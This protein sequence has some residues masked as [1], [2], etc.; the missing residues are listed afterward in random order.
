MPPSAARP[1]GF[2]LSLAAEGIAPVIGGCAGALAGGSEGGVAGVVVGQVVER[3]INYFGPRIVQNWLGWLR[4]QPR[5]GQLAAIAEL[6]TLPPEV[7]RREAAAAVDR[8]AAA[9]CSTEDRTLAV[10]YLTAIPGAVQ[11]SLVRDRATGA[12]TLLAAAAPDSSQVLLRLLP[13]DVPPYPAGSVLPGTSYRLEEL[14]GTGGFGAVYRATDPTLQ[15][16]TLAIK[17]CLEPSM[18]TTLHQ[19]R[20]ILDR[21]MSAGE[22]DWSPGIVRLYGY[23]LEHATPFLVYEYVPG[24]DLGAHLA[25]RQAEGKPP[26]PREVL[27][28]VVQVVEALAFAHARGLVH[29]DLKPANVLLAADG[30]LKLADFGIGSALAQQ[31]AQ[32]G[33][34][35][36]SALPHLTMLEQASLFRGAGTPLYMSQEQK[37]NDPPDPRHDLYSL[38]VLWYQLLVGDVTRELHPNWAKELA[39]KH[40]TPPE[41]IAVLERCVGWFEER[42]KDGGALLALLRPLAEPPV[43]RAAPAADANPALDERFRSTILRGQ[44]TTLLGCHENLGMV[45]AR[46]GHVVGGVLAGLI[47]GVAGGIGL[48][49]FLYHSFN[50]PPRQDRLFEEFI[51]EPVIYLVA[52]LFGLSLFGLCLW[53]GI[54]GMRRAYARLRQEIT[55]KAGKMA[56]AFPAAVQAWGGPGVLEDKN[57]VKG[58]LEV[59]Q[60]K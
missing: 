52:I 5:E 11:R 4:G 51:P 58:I 29:R 10:E 12:L 26:S 48:W 21:L 40:Q 38:G 55:D 14:L 15:Y 35:G 33:R 46:G 28:W 32:Q 27:G 60:G 47:G 43:A 13:A 42:A 45:E 17:F 49:A 59:L 57:A 23:N 50:K 16:L 24:G 25:A 1:R 8:L 18:A 39:V 9:D 19:E 54:H 53:G 6:A 41:H 31:A 56:E 30:R 37:R 22:G 2:L 7:A 44:L 36:S 34:L 20:K 3:A